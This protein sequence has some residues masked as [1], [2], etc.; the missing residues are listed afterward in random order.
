[1]L[2]LLTALSLLLCVAVVV[3][4]PVSY[5]WHPDMSWGASRDSGFG[6]P[7]HDHKIA[8]YD[9][10]L[11]YQRSYGQMGDVTLAPPPRHAAFLGCG[12]TR[13]YWGMVPDSDWSVYRCLI[14]FPLYWL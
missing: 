13:G 6:W 4:I 14:D 9:G 3:L 5:F 12:V 7:L 10:R 1:M 2:N 11:F 8:L